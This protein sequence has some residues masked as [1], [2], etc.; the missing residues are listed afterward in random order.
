MEVN[1]KMPQQNEYKCIDVQA[2]G[3]PVTVKVCD[4]DKGKLFLKGLAV[5]AGLVILER[6]LIRINSRT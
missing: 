5:F 4:D 3:L 1:I 2:N 6:I